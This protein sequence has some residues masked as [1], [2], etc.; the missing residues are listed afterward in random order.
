[1]A[2]CSVS[3]RDAHGGEPRIRSACLPARKTREELDFSFQR[4]VTKTVI[5]HLGQ[6][7]FPHSTECVLALG[8]PGTGKTHLAI[9]LGIRACLAGH[10]VRFAGATEWV[11]RLKEA[12]P[13]GRLE[14]SWLRSRESR[15]SLSTRSDAFR[16]TRRRPTGC[17]R[18][19]PR[20]MS[21]RQPT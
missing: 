12:R 1:M 5:E 6:L 11:T 9:V 4:S 15:C 17:S 3:A 20:A 21:A 19:S 10:G 2:A 7:D 13:D 18:S 14:A 16:L 8:P